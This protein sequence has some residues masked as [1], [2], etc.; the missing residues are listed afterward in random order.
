[1]VAKRGISLCRLR[2]SCRGE[3]K[4]ALAITRQTDCFC[5]LSHA[6]QDIDKASTGAFAGIRG[7]CGRPHA[8]GEARIRVRSSGKHGRTVIDVRRPHERDREQ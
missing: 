4:K 8:A 6:L 3:W 1:M 7:R 5:V 2:F